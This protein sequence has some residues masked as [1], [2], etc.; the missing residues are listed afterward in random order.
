MESMV[1]SQAL[2]SPKSRI[3]PAYSETLQLK[4]LDEHSTPKVFLIHG[5]KL[6]S[7]CTAP[8]DWLN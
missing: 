7:N 1:A 3:D 6:D 2:L 8:L 5:D 4:A